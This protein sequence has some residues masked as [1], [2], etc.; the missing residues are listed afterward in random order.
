[1]IAYASNRGF[2]AASVT[3][4]CALT[5]YAWT[6]GRSIASLTSIVKQ[7]DV[8]SYLK[9]N[10]TNTQTYKTHTPQDSIFFFLM[11]KKNPNFYFF[12]VEGFFLSFFLSFFFFF[13]LAGGKEVPWGLGGEAEGN[14]TA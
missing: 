4:I 2:L 9:K 12:G 1:M 11:G 5:P 7:P 8:T 14:S 3:A 6:T 10:T 13:F